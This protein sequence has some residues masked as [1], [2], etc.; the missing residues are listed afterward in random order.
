MVEARVCRQCG[1][2]RTD[3][4][5]G[6][7]CPACRT[8]A[9]EVSTGPFAGLANAPTVA[10][11]S[12]SFPSLE[13]LGLLGRGGM[14][15]VY[16]ARQLKLDRT[17]ALKILAP[18]PDGGA[19]A[20]RFLRE[21]RALARL[22]HPHIVTVH[23]F[24]EAGQLFYFVMEFVE[25]GSL[26]ELLRKGRPPLAEALALSNPCCSSRAIHWQSLTSVLRPETCL[27]CSA[28]AR[29]TWQRPSRMWKAGFQ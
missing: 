24:G 20:E 19:F 13:V 21:A 10:A 12:A 1:A 3:D 11:L 17:V 25:G 27:M 2:T 22:S 26:R 16:K 8:P 15:T 9:P 28:L 7:L 6:D 29:I 5:P 18:G 23:D 4:T 14:G